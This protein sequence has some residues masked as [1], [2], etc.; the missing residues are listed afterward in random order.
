V[1][2]LSDRSFGSPSIERKATPLPAHFRRAISRRILLSI[3]AAGLAIPAAF[4]LSH[5]MATIPTKKLRWVVFYGQT[6]DEVLL[7]TYDIVILDPG[8]LGSIDAVAASGAQVFGY[9]S[10]GEIRVA[11]SFFDRVDPEAVLGTSLSSEGARKL[12]IRHPSWQSLV[13]DQ[14]IPAMSAQGFTG[15]MLDT[16]DTPAYL[17]LIDGK[18]NAGMRQ[19]AIDLVHTIR[20][21]YPKIKLIANRGYALLPKLVD[22]LDA[23]IAESLL[24]RPNLSGSSA[25]AEASE[26]SQQLKLLAPATHRAK[27]L[28]ILSLDYWQPEDTAA[29]QLI[30]SR[31]RKLGHHPYVTTPLMDQIIPEPQTA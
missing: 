15:L 26:V 30:Y 18:R 11:S 4:G 19:A 2:Q 9:L 22:I 6:T 12:D 24:T 29:I 17:E 27:P 13:L 16:L 10:L 8:F 25:W 31:E 21:R 5:Y 3:M 28:P 1:G 14:L 7:A 23:L 20:K